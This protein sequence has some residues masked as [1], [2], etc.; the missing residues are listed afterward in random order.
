MR[1]RL[2][3]KCSWLKKLG[4]A[5]IT[6][7]PFICFSYAKELVSAVTVRHEMIHVEQIRRS[8]ILWFYIVYLW[9]YVKGMFKHRFN[10]DLAYQNIRAEVEAYSRQGTLFTDAEKAELNKSGFEC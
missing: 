1:V 8:N 9:D 4:Y 6:L 3:F 5:G 7:Y 2:I 10:H